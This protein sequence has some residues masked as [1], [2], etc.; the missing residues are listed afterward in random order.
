MCRA[1]HDHCRVLDRL[2]PSLSSFLREFALASPGGSALERSG[3]TGGIVPEMPD[4]S[5]VNAVVYEDA[6]ELESQLGGVAGAYDEAGVDA[7]GVWAHESD[8]RA[9]GAL[10]AAGSVF[11]SEPMVMGRE[12]AGMEEPGPDELDLV[13]DPDVA[14]VSEVLMP[15]YGWERFDTAMRWYDGYHPYLALVDGRPAATLGVHDHD[16]DAYVTWVGTIE[17]A[18]GR[19]LA[20]LLMRRALVDARERGC[21]TTTLIATRMGHPV[22]ARLGYR[23]FGR[24]QMWERRKPAA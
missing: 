3:V 6:G 20:S 13:T 2:L 18:R 15:V 9:R 12:L 1:I 7:W 17:D 5:V 24:L 11:D 21:T 19:G 4:R 10:E 14:A 22:Y 8:D 23:E 16:G